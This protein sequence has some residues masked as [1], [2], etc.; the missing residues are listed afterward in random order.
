MTEEESSTQFKYTNMNSK[1]NRQQL[2][3]GKGRKS[4]PKMNRDIV[5]GKGVLNEVNRPH[6][7]LQIDLL[8]VAMLFLIISSIIMIL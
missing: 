8:N 6:P 2:R 3:N 7:Y 4:L 1:A 5:R